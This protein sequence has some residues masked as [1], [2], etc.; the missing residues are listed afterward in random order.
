MPLIEFEDIVREI[1]SVDLLV[2]ERKRW[3]TSAHKI[4]KRFAWHTPIALNLGVEEIVV[5][6]KYDLLFAI[7][8]HPS[9]LLILKGVKGWRD[10]AKV[11]I[12]L[13]MRFG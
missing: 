11:K 3:F 12:C 4:A 2:L 9:D 6:G 13:V 1:D 10:C 7:V 8:G 5:K